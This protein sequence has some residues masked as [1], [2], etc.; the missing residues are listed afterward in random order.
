MTTRSLSLSVLPVRL[1]AVRFDPR[2]TVPRPPRDADFW[3]VTVYDNKGGLTDVQLGTVLRDDDEFDYNNPMPACTPPG[4]Q[5]LYTAYLE[6]ND[7]ATP[8]GTDTPAE[9][10][11][12]VSA[13]PS[14]CARSATV[15]TR[16]TR[17]NV[18]LAVC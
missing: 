14:S 3:S 1:A 4:N 9:G 7:T 12:Q 2:V 15:L 16:I 17:S 18:S 11:N 5:R 6:S 13:D 10:M 8:F